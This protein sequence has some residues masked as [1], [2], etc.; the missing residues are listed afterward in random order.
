MDGIAA[1]QE[2]ISNCFKDN[3]KGGMLFKLDFAKS[4]D[5]LDLGFIMEVLRARKIGTKRINWID[6]CLKGG[7]SHILVNGCLDRVIY[8]RRRLRQGDPLS[9]LLFVIA[10][11][12]FTKMLT[13]IVRTG[14]LEGLGPIGFQKQ[15]VS[16]QH[17]DDTLLLC[18]SEKNYIRSFKLLFYGFELASGLNINF[19]KSSVIVLEDNMEL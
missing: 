9:P 7:K 17:V 14:V 3:I 6:K 18:E 11:D 1:A 15:V 16:L 10:A 4:Y 5:M 19:G 13:L 2:I 12:S 8:S